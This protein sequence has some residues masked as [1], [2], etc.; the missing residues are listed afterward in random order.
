MKRWVIAGAGALIWT[1]AV[2][3]T[4]ASDMSAPDP[5]MKAQVQAPIGQSWYGSYIGVNGGYAWGS[6]AVEFAPD[7][8]Y[9]PLLLTAGIPGSLAAKPQGFLGGITYG[10]NYQFNS[11]VIGLDSDFDWSSIKA[12]QTV[13]GLVTGVPFTATANQE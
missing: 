6:N 7:V 2:S 8:F 13:N 9:A 11:V 1:A 12:S 3:P 10:S 4:G 5:I